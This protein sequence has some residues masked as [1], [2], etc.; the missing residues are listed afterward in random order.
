MSL[1][2]FSRLSISL[3]AFNASSIVLPILLRKSRACSL[4]L[5]V[6]MQP[7]PTRFQLLP[8]SWADPHRTHFSGCFIPSVTEYLYGLGCYFRL[9]L[10]RRG[11]PSLSSLHASY[12][13]ACL[14]WSTYLFF[15][16]S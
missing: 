9:L 15:L 11:L 5:S 12:F 2:L 16:P 10:P 4:C 6:H 3:T 14:A 13:P 1:S 7:P 8:P